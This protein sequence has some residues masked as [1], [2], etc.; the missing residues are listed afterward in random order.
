MFLVRS[1]NYTQG[2]TS[3]AKHVMHIHNMEKD[4]HPSIKHSIL[5]TPTSQQQ[6]PSA[7]TTTARFVGG[8]LST[9]S[10]TQKA[11]ARN[12]QILLMEARF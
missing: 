8:N 11:I 12:P 9:S 4:K 5:Q 7:D 10:F 1:S 3:D 2:T 6:C